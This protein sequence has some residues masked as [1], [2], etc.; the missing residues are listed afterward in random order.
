MKPPLSLPLLFLTFPLFAFHA[1]MKLP[2]SDL[3]CFNAT[4]P[5][6]SRNDF[7]SLKLPVEDSIGEF[8]S[9]GWSS[10]SLPVQVGLSAAGVIGA[11][12]IQPYSY[13]FIYQI[14]ILKF[15][16]STKPLPEL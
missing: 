4:L 3:T 2:V 10:L 15:W 6:Y 16:F 11:V 9:L 13:L 8:I 1:P 7:N 12:F 14:L 5:T